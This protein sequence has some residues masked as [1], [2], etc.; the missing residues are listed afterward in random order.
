VL[1]LK[2]GCRFPVPLTHISHMIQI[3]EYRKSQIIGAQHDL[4]Q[5]PI[6]DFRD[7]ALD[8]QGG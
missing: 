4:R 5:F 3:A 8:N 1:N 7:S 6:L 2:P